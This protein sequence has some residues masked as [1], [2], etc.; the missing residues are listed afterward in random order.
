ML[1]PCRKFVFGFSTGHVGTT[2]LSNRT[3]YRNGAA[4][5]SDFSF[6]FEPDKSVVR[7]GLSIH[8]QE[9]HVRNVY[10]NQLSRRLAGTRL[11]RACVDLSHFTLLFFEGLI[12][13]LQSEG[14]PFELVRIRRDAVET[15]RS[16]GNRFVV[17][18]R[19]FDAPESLQL[20]V[21]KRVYT[22]FTALESGLYAVDETEA[23]WRKIL[24][25]RRSGHIHS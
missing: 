18:F 14:L 17:G 8:A 5:L 10:L 13:V 3:T 21:D 20:R 4:N 24:M 2:T 6:F 19:P 15:A 23:Q 25:G 11:L 12:R 7:H 16:L 9:D 22:T 1:P